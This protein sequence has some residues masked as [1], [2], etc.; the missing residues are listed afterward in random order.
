MSQDPYH[1]LT[2]EELYL[3]EQLEKRLQRNIKES[4]NQLLKEHLEDEKKPPKDWMQY[5]KIS[6]K[7][8]K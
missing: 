4:F 5:L 6:V 2:P 3:I 8:D 7:E 1:R